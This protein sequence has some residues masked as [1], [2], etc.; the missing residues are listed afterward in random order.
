MQVRCGARAAAT[1]W[2]PAASSRAQAS[3]SAPANGSAARPKETR[4]GPAHHLPHDMGG[5][6]LVH[7]RVASLAVLL[8]LGG[9]WAGGELRATVPDDPV[10]RDGAPIFGMLLFARTVGPALTALPALIAVVA[11][12]SCGSARGCTTCLPAGSRSW[13]SRFSRRRRGPSFP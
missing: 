1:S 4:C 12:K 10:V 5:D 2:P 3:S 13:R 7:R 6:R 9:T 8:V 11:V